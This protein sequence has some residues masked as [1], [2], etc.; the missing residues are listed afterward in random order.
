MTSIS[1]VLFTIEIFLITKL[2]IETGFINEGNKIKQHTFKFELH[3][4][5]FKTT[6]KN[7]LI[8]FSNFL[9]GVSRSSA[10]QI[11]LCGLGKPYPGIIQDWGKGTMLKK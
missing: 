6:M 11:Q 8:T 1:M 4:F 5:K 3:P 10:Q 7:R 9:G 2:L